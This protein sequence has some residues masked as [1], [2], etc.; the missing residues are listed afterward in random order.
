MRKLGLTSLPVLAAML[1]LSGC[2]GGGG[3]ASTPAPVPAPTPAPTPT[4]TPVPTPTPTPTATN[5]NTS[6]YRRSD[7]PAFHGAITAWDAGASGQGTTIAIVDSGIDTTN[8]EFSGRIAGSSTDVGGTRGLINGDDD[9]GTQVALVAA[10]ARNNTGVMGIAWSATIQMLRADTP[11]SCLDADGCTFSD[12]NITAG[13]DS[14]IRAGAR[15]VNL[16]LGG[17]AANATLRAA[18]G[19]AAAAGLVVVVSAGNDGDSTEAGVDPS[20]PDPFAASVLQAG[21]AN[22][23]IVGSVDEF[24]VVSNFSNR[25]GTSASSTLMALGQQ[26]CC[27]Y[28]NGVIKTETTTEGTFVRV[29]SGTSFSAPQVSGAA[30][31]LAQAFPNLTA[32]QIVSLLL[33]SARDAGASGTDATYGRGIL[34][35]ARAFSPQGSTGLAGTSVAVSLGS[36]AGMTSAAMGDAISGA[37]LPTVMLDGYARAYR[38]D[39]AQGLRAGQARQP[40]IEALGSPARSIALDA[41][42]ATLAFSVDRR[43]GAAPLRLASGDRD[44]AKVLAS[45]LVTRL[46]DKFDVAL[47]W[48][49]AGQGLTSQLQRRHEPVFLIA[50]VGSGLAERSQ[51]GLAVRYRIGGAGLTVNAERAEVWRPEALQNRRIDRLVRF[52]VAVDGRRSAGLDW[53]VGLGLMR[54]DRT[55]LGARF[56]EALGGGG[57]TT[58]SFAPGVTWRP[59]TGWQL[60]A[61][62]NLG[63]TRIDR[64]AI[65]ANG[66]RL[67]SSS[68]AVDLA[69]DGMLAAGDRLALRLSQPLRVESGALLLNLPVGYDYATGLASFSRVPLSLAPKGREIDAELAWSLSALGGNVATSLFWRRNPGHF[70]AVSDDGGAAVRWSAAF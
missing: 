17:D 23:L 20:N 8:P 29:V 58:V 3:V 61:S 14:A 31:L 43:F 22:V 2:G 60:A 32:K 37:S 33:S 51:T 68:W 6:E 35:I 11:G 25:P 62:G 42:G 70:A 41:D 36:L 7:G 39:L 49:V 19:R 34:D 1:A 53:R 26:I 45:S 9:H 44:R 21:G 67:V 66:S 64:G 52:G 30:A 10:A 18:V 55:V 48:N 69:R 50:G 40:L 15:V 12:E 38:L 54:E 47:G 46:G 27:V 24:G 57:A 63:I 59:A 5:F 16:S 56:A 4:P 65:T 13:I 28:E